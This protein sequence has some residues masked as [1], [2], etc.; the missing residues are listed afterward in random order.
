MFIIYNQ[1]PYSCKNPLDLVVLIIVVSFKE[2]RMGKKEIPIELIQDP[3]KR[4]TTF[5][6]RH[7][8]VQKKAD[9]ISKLCNVKT[10]LIYFDEKDEVY[11][12]CNM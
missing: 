7:L 5:G 12:Y 6:K 3:T 8:G 11:S 1:F 9:E 10:L 2:P 4:R